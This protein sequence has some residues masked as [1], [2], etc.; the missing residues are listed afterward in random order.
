MSLRPILLAAAISYAVPLTVYSAENDRLN[1]DERIRVGHVY[2]K[3]LRNKEVQEARQAYEQAAKQYH[4]ALRSAMIK[5]DPEIQPALKKIKQNPG[6]LAEAIWEKR[7]NDILNNLHLPVSR[8]DD[9]E[10]QTWNKAMSKLREKELTK[11]FGRRL[12][13]NYKQQ[14]KLRK[15]QIALMSEFKKEAQRKLEQIDSNVRPLLEKLRSPMPA[16]EGK[17]GKDNGG[18]VEPEEEILPMPMPMPVPPIQGVSEE[19]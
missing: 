11:V 1:R 10:R 6:L 2:S 7:N 9:K 17:G 3:V 18:A 13:K 5:R 4:A 14:V 15:E 19:C 12:E 8:L 16:A